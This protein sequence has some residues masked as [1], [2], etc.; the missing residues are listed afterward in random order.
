MCLNTRCIYYNQSNDWRRRRAVCYKKGGDVCHVIP[1]GKRCYAVF[2]ADTPPALIALGANAKLISSG[3]ER[4]VPLSHLYT[5]DGKEPLA[6][7]SG[8]VLAEI[9]VPRPLVKQSSI[10]L[11]YR[12]RSAID[13]PL[14]GVAVRLDLND[15][16]CTDC[17][18]VLT[19]V[20]SAPIEVSEVGEILKGKVLSDELVDRASEKVMK[21]A[22]PVANTL[23]STPAYRRKMARILARRGLLVAAKRGGLVHKISTEA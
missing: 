10:Y 6:I 12:I 14:V 1:K 4:T 7:K 5:G 13:F 20:S 18:V 2:S 16:I 21:S 22:N 19:A 3:G 8:E 15:G 17:R 23:G 11:K 9:I